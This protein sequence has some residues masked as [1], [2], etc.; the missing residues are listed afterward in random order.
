LNHHVQISPSEA[1]ALGNPGRQR[2]GEHAGRQGVVF[3]PPT[4]TDIKELLQGIDAFP[5]LP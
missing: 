4:F 5:G 1:N 3:S 2:F